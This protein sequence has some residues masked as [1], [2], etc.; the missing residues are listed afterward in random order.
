[1]RGV[2][3]VNDA[4]GLREKLQRFYDDGSKHSRYQNVPKF[5]E[6]ELGYHEEINETWRGDSARLEFLVNN[7]PLA[8]KNTVADIGAN[9]GFF[10]LS[11]AHEFRT[12]KFTAYEPHLAHCQF[13][14]TIVE[15]FGVPN[16]AVQNEA[17]DLEKLG[18]MPFY[19][20]ILLLNILHHAGVDF[21]HHLVHSR[22]EFEDY[23][24]EY[25]ARLS[26]KCN[27]LVLQL[28]YRWGGNKAEPL[29][30]VGDIGAMLSLIKRL[31]KGNWRIA[32]V[33]LYERDDH[34][35]HYT[36]VLPGADGN[37]TLELDQL[38]SVGVVSEFY[39]RPI[40]LMQSAQA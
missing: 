32:Q 5:V 31:A 35:G 27:N 7:L 16:V 23:A 30:P 37:I 4:I 12:A 8:G 9:T 20:V 24:S 14:Q 18:S 22:H 3:A 1:M 34:L 29:L 10:T 13:I 17:V 40:L 28:G 2:R 15:H 6:A 25:L 19:D 21:D 39:R 11:L 36:S 38:T 26:T 33:G